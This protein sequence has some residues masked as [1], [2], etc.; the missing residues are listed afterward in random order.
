MDRLLQ[1]R[2]AKSVGVFGDARRERRR[3]CGE[4]AAELGSAESAQ[5]GT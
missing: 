3:F 4:M 2:A 5:I 1:Q